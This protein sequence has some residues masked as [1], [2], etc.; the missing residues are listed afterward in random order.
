MI[1]FFI[2][3]KTAHCLNYPE[4]RAIYEIYCSNVTVVFP[5]ILLIVRQ[6]GARGAPLT[7]C[8]HISCEIVGGRGRAWAG[9]QMLRYFLKIW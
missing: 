7:M 6:C 5:P 1:Y 4:P 9:T 3:F 8:T 2:P